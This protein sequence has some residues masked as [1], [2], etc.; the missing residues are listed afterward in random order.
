MIPVG[1]KRKIIKKGV[2]CMYGSLPKTPNI[3]K[4]W[5]GIHDREDWSDELKNSIPY[6][7]DEC[8]NATDVEGLWCG[9]EKEGALCQTWDDHYNNWKDDSTW[10]YVCH[11]NKWKKIGQDGYTFSPSES[12][13]SKP[14]HNNPLFVPLGVPHVT[15]DCDT[16]G[17]NNDCSKYPVGSYCGKDQGYFCNDDFKWIPKKQ[18]GKA[19]YEGWGKILKSKIPKYYTKDEASS[20]PNAKFGKACTEP[21]GTVIYGGHTPQPTSSPDSIA[22]I[23]AGDD[24]N[25][26]WKAN[27]DPS[28]DF[29][30]NLRFISLKENDRKVLQRYPVSKQST[31]SPKD[32]LS[33][34]GNSIQLIDEK[35]KMFNAD[36]SSPSNENKKLYCSNYNDYRKH[37]P[38]LCK[39]KLASSETKDLLPEVC[40]TS[41]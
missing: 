7:K 41:S 16:D 30:R 13:T 33:N 17:N 21:S 25:K 4:T 32:C 10:G 15:K 3:Y 34:S 39:D 5:V 37:C 18:S 19:D 2:I 23:C 11:N 36:C 38:K 20:I 6:V 35:D 28:D 14:I 40:K 29:T 24:T 27:G 9:D 12:G 31:L 8:P 1:T 22:F 26:T